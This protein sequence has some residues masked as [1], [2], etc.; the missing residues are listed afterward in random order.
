MAEQF[1]FTLTLKQFK[2]ISTII[3]RVRDTRYNSGKV[4]G[5]NEIIEIADR[6]E[7]AAEYVEDNKP[8]TAQETDELVLWC[9]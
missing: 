3:S 7:K 8:M 4:E 1:S 6:L 9:L 5:L 2:E